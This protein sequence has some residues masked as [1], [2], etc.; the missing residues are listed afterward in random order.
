LTFLKL[1]AYFNGFSVGLD[2]K[3][4]VIVEDDPDLQHLFKSVLLKAGFEIKLLSDGRDL[5]DHEYFPDL[6]ILDIELPFITGLELC[7]QI[8]ACLPTRHIPVLIVSASA[9]LL[10]QARNVCADDSLAKPFDANV[11]ISR[12]TALLS[13]SSERQPTFSSAEEA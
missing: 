9:N 11:L 8:K 13:N 7:K 4:I 3:K 12:V 1:T 6:F 10:A 2:M 5:F